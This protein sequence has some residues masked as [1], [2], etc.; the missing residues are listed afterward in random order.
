MTQRPPG[1]VFVGSLPVVDVCKDRLLFAVP[2]RG[3]RDL[4]RHHNDVGA[5]DFVLFHHHAARFATFHLHI[6]EAEAALSRSI[7]ARWATNS[8]TGMMPDCLIVTTNDS[9]VIRAND[10]RMSRASGIGFSVALRDNKREQTRSC[11]QKLHSTIPDRNAAAAA[12]PFQSPCQRDALGEVVHRARR[13]NTISDRPRFACQPIIREI[14]RVVRTPEL[15][16]YSYLLHHYTYCSAVN[17]GIRLKREDSMLP[18]R[19][20]DEDKDAWT[21][22]H[23]RAPS[24]RVSYREKAP[25]TGIAGW[26]T[27]NRRQLESG[28]GGREST[29]EGSPSWRSAPPHRA[30]GC[31]TSPPRGGGAEGAGCCTFP[32]RALGPRGLGD[33][34]AVFAGGVAGVQAKDVAEP[35][36]VSVTA[37]I[38]DALEPASRWR[39]A[40]DLARSMRCQAMTRL[41]RTPVSSRKRCAR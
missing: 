25:E 39:R 21:K 17:T 7:S 30:A 15:A 8:S 41:M 33:A 22:S 26:S 29:P 24:P 11:V 10:A 12:H 6:E 5:G 35:V 23:Q 4:P 36:R 34:V 13:T 18:P 16:F 9:L 40:A 20:H 1:R 27:R 32:K 19:E 3:H 38:G 31:G 28:L 14:H 37:F 2:V